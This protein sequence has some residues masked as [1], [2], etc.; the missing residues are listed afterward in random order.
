[1]GAKASDLLNVLRT[2]IGWSEANG[3]FKYIIDIYN[4]HK[5]LPRGYKVKYSDEW[6]DVGLTAA[7]IVAKATDITGKECGVGEHVRIFQKLGIWNE[8]GKVTPKIGDIIVYNWDDKTQPNDGWPDHIGVVES[9]KKDSMVVIECNYKK[10]VG[11]RTISIGAGTIRGYARPKYDKEV[12][13]KSL[14]LLVAEI[15]K[16]EWGNGQE[17]IKNLEQAGYDY[18]VIQ[19]EV[20]KALEELKKPKLK[21]IEDIAREVIAGKWGNGAK[22]KEMLVASGYKYS[23]VQKKVNELLK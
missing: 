22:R 9:V 12:P 5:P 7:S 4:S 8:D 23:D 19:Y 21:P 1:M 10:S 17:R 14:S 20:N 3:K 13:T 15:L 2:W 18:K 11:R 16:G 6:C